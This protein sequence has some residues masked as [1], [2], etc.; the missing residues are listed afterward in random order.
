[1]IVFDNIVYSLQKSGGISR[2][3]SKITEPYLDTAPF[4]EREDATV[5]LYRQAQQ[6]ANVLP[7]HRLFK[8][9]SRYVNFRLDA[10][11]ARHVFHS[12]YYRINR[13][14]G[15]INVTTI[16][17]LIYE[18]FGGS[19]LGSRLHIAQ[20]RRSLAA[21][22]CI[23][24]VS[25]HTRSDLYEYY[26]LTRDKRVLVIPNGV[27]PAPPNGSAQEI[28]H[29]ARAAAERGAFF[30]YVGHRGSC[31][32]FDR[33]YQALKLCDANLR[34]V[35]VGD[36]LQK[37]EQEEIAAAGLTDR[38]LAVGRVSDSDLAFLYSHAEFFFFPSLYEG[39]GIP[40]LE[41]MQLGC[42]VLASN[43]SSVPE[44]VG[45]AGVL[46]DPE[47]AASLEAGLARIRAPELRAGFID[48]GHQRAA[49]LSWQ[50]AAAQY[51]DLY[52]ELLA[53]KAG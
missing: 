2:F 49:A 17:D 12:S 45:E 34:C 10:G 42:P 20:K 39:F 8:T 11:G 25:E 9:L 31:K 19:Q 37:H 13:A 23:V 53:E 28:G 50:S 7:D 15:A 26:P 29:T 18:R 38:V 22:D 44:V 32:G 6:I 36:A 35:V 46:F 51:R 40:P 30:L 4:I 33:V 27:D 24:C 52:S 14:P 43:R 47:D 5:N 3:W 41:A 1:M 16:H 21:A 48:A